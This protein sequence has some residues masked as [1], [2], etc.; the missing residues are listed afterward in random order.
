MQSQIQIEETETVLQW[1][2]V[3]E[4]IALATALDQYGPNAARS[5]EQAIERYSIAA[6]DTAAELDWQSFCSRGTGF[7]NKYLTKATDSIDAPLPPAL[8]CSGD[9][10]ERPSCALGHRITALPKLAEG[11]SIESVAFVRYLL[12]KPVPP[13]AKAL[14]IQF[15]GCVTRSDAV[16]A[17]WP[18]TER[19][20]FGQY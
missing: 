1:I 10:P 6:G 11:A 8:Q 4:S 3:P 14:P 15:G 7:L 9:L 17:L 19:A 13:G 16:S 5:V 18:A 12:R 2:R 20:A